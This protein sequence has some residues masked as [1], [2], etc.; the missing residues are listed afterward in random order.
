MNKIIISTGI[1][2]SGKST[3]AKSVIESDLSYVRF[4]RDDARAMINSGNPWSH[5]KTV[6]K[7]MV[8]DL[9]TTLRNSFVISSLE[10]GMNIII[11]ETN[12][13]SRTFKEVNK[14]L[15]NY[16]FDVIVEEKIFY[17]DLETALERDRNRTPKVGDDI[18][19]KYFNRFKGENFKGY[20]PKTKIFN[21]LP[22]L[23]PILNSNDPWCVVCDLDGTLALFGDK[24]PYNRDFENDFANFPVSRALI[25]ASDDSYKIILVSGRTE[26][27]REST[28]KFLERYN[29]KAHDL[30]M[31]KSGDYRN[32]MIVKY[33]IYR[34][35]IRGK[36]NVLYVLDDRTR[37]V[38]M[39]RNM[40]LTCFQVA[41]GDF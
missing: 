23:T 33:E 13:E 12:A 5:F 3:W 41:E 21:M 27:H 39:W 22:Y 19:I 1:P 10:T 9:V 28:I 2:A 15:S 4:N 8:E 31:R 36:Y 20:H 6:N 24:N 11:D 26:E 29:I 32:D 18:V 14:L 30:L 34:D 40:G 16:N 38:K 17:V 35:Y 25:H 7:N 37:V